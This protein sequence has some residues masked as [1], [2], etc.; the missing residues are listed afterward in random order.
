MSDRKQAI[1]TR[2]LENSVYLP[3]AGM[4]KELTEAL[5]KLSLVNLVNLQMILEI[6]VQDAVRAEKEPLPLSPN[7]SFIQQKQKEAKAARELAATL[8]NETAANLLYDAIRDNLNN[9]KY[10]LGPISDLDIRRRQDAID[11]TNVADKL[12]MGKLDFAY[13]AAS[14]LDTA[15]RDE[16]PMAVWVY[17]GG[18]LVHG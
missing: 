14:Q 16:I 18:D 13:E 6:K 5:A 3:E 4:R 2:I 15:V 7:Q 1:V 12:R 8:T 10:P 17:L 9:G 11:L